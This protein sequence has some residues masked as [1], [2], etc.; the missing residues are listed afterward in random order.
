MEADVWNFLT[1]RPIM[2]PLYLMVNIAFQVVQDHRSSLLSTTLTL[3]IQNHT[4]LL[5]FA[6]GGGSLQDQCELDDFFFT[7]LMHESPY[8]HDFKKKLGYQV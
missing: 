4:K 3:T 8:V 6:D 5:R 1:V 2:L 7:F